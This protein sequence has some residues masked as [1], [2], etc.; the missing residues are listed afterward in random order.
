MW[1]EH[2]KA[3]WRGDLASITAYFEKAVIDIE[4][5]TKYLTTIA[6][7]QAQAARSLAKRS[8]WL[9]SEA[10]KARKVAAN[11]GNLLGL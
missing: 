9:Y 8:E 7:N 5:H 2:L 4:A 1:F 3:W 11:I 10:D 6:D